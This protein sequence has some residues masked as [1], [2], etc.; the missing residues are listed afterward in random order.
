[1]AEHH[2]QSH[3]A[4][5]TTNP[6]P[7]VSLGLTAHRRK[8]S[9]T[10]PKAEG[11]I[12]FTNTSQGR[13][14]GGISPDWSRLNEK[15]DNASAPSPRAGSLDGN[16]PNTTSPAGCGTSSFGCFTGILCNKNTRSVLDIAMTVRRGTLFLEWGLMGGL[17]GLKFQTWMR[18]EVEDGCFWLETKGTSCTTLLE[19]CM[20]LLIAEK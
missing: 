6:S 3:A 8:C 12:V 11:T 2:G 10:C 13:G 5:D 19:A 18:P 20:K 7:V 1:M 4:C 15:V 17:W 16:T 9:T 14:E